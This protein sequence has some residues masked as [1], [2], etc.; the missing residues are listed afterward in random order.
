MW[1]PELTPGVCLFVLSA[2]PLFS[3]RCGPLGGLRVSVCTAGHLG[4]MYTPIV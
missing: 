2:M 1:H 4:N 3:M